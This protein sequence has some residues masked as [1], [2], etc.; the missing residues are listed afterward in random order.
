MFLKQTGRS[1]GGFYLIELLVVLV[2]WACWPAWPVPRAIGYLGGAK[3]DTARLQIEESV[4][5]WISSNWETGR[6]PHDKKA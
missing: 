2:I 6:Y 4:L 5:A 1:M 3:S